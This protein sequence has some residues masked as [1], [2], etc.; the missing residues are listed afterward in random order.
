MM[1][2]HKSI[3]WQLGTIRHHFKAYPSTQPTPKS[4]CPSPVWSVLSI[5]PWIPIVLNVVQRPNSRQV[6]CLVP[7]IP[8]HR[9]LRQVI[10]ASPRLKWATKWVP[11][12]FELHKETLYL[13]KKLKNPL[14]F[15]MKI[16]DAQNYE[17]KQCL[18]Q[19]PITF[20]NKISV[21]WFNLS[22]L[23]FLG[24]FEFVVFSC[25]V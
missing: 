4:L 13:K 1:I 21:L 6:W 23:C 10:T 20:L 24:V 11:G 15:E 2:N 16:H 14:Q 18:L 7:V 5:S 22:H 17:G 25:A 3:F 9:R 8:A 19:I 12:Q